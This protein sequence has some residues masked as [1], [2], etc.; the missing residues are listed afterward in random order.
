MFS[1][2]HQARMDR[3]AQHYGGLIRSP[4]LTRRDRQVSEGYFI[5]K[6]IFHASII[7][8]LSYTLQ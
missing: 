6:F 3:E 7:F 5:L 8:Y 4:D 1:H 2:H